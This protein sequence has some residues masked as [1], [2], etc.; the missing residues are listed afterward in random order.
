VPQGESEVAVEGA[1]AV[2]PHL[3]VHPHDHLGVRVGHET[4]AAGDEVAPQLQVVEYL[5]VEG[6]VDGGVVIGHRLAAADRVNYAQ[7]GV[8]QA[9]VVI[10]MNA[11]L[12]GSAVGDR[13][14]HGLQG[15]AAGD[16]PPWSAEIA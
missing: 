12:V 8:T 2:R 16:G 11:L 13:S 14:D 7:P 10:D 3:L 5:A 1:H 9:D 6:D 4:V 15:K